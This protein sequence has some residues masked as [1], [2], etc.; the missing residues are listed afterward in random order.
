MIVAAWPRSANAVPRKMIPIAARNSGIES[1][2]NTDPN[3]TGNAVHMI[4]STKISHTW[5][6]SQTGLIDRCTIPRSRPPRR[7]PPAVRSQNPAPKSALPSTAYAVM[8][9]ATKPTQT[10]SRL[11]R[12]P[13]RRAAG[14]P[15][16]QPD[17]GGAEP[18]VDDDQEHVADRQPVDRRDGLLGAHHR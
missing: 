18:D 16:Q 10:S 5:L 8:P 14:Q 2:E 4:T 6:A 15:A 9:S 7:A 3:A 1:V 13:A 11:T 12:P 17:D